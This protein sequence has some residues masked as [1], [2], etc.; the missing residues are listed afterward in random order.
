MYLHLDSLKPDRYVYRITTLERVK[1]LF[2][3]H[4]N[5]LVAPIK[6][7]DPFEN[8][9]LASPVKLNS[10]KVVEYP[11]H[12]K[13]YGQ[14]WTFHKASDAMWRIYAPSG[15]GVRIRSSVA[16]LGRILEQAHPGHTDARCCVGRVRYLGSNKMR[17][18]A[19]TTFD[20]SGIAADKLFG[21]LLVKRPAFLHERELRLLYLEIDDSKEKSDTYNYTADPHEMISQIMLD[22]RMSYEDYEKVRSDIKNTT[23]F[24]GQIL[25]SLLYAA[26]KREV[27][28]VSEWEP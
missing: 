25:R 6:W 15:N 23:G 16:T 9:I 10:G 17:K 2:S 27:L 1:A 3:T 22:P 13:I 19:N 8:F 18:L 24:Q 7:D 4:Q 14:C 26:P 11:F 5:V 28:G 20:D 12:E 21:S